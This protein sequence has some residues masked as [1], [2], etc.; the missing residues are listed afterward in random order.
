AHQWIFAG[1]D[2]AATDSSGRW[3]LAPAAPVTVRAELRGPFVAVTRADVPSPEAGDARFSTDAAADATVDFTWGDAGFSHEAE[4]DAFRNANVA[5]DAAK[6][7]DPAFTGL[8]SPM[9]VIV[10]YPYSH[11]NAQWT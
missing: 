6:A 10:N 7:L 4:R 11:C 8:D 1:D 9:S 5:H 2:S 3:S